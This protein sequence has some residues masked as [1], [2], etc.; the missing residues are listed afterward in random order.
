MDAQARYARSVSYNTRPRFSRSSSAPRC[1][2]AGPKTWRRLACGTMHN[3]WHCTCPA[4]ADVTARSHILFTNPM[5][6]VR[7]V[8]SI[9]AIS[10]APPMHNHIAH[11]PN[12]SPYLLTL[13]SSAWHHL[14]SAPPPLTLPRLC[15]NLFVPLVALEI[16]QLA[17]HRKSRQNITGRASLVPKLASSASICL[18][19][20]FHSLCSSTFV[21]H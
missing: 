13:A 12:V 9:C 18:A 6:T 8:Y 21:V 11:P 19:S 1:S 10:P 16:L 14:T 2:S 3:V 7:C 20:T 15:L 17:W 5:S 4:L